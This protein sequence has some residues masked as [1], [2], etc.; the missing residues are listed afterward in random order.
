MAAKVCRSVLLLSRS[1]GA[2]ASAFPAFGVSSHRHHRSTRTACP[3]ALDGFC[4]KTPL[5]PNESEQEGRQASL[6]LIS[7]T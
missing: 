4:A 5:L 1:S 7:S 6:G 2:V 3:Q